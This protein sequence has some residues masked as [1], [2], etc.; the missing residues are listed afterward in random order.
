MDFKQAKI[1]FLNAWGALGIAWGVNKTTAQIFALLFISP[2]PL[3][4]EQ[5]MEE[6]DISRGNSSMNLRGLMDWDLIYKTT[7]KGDRREYF[8]TDKDFWTLSKKVTSERAKKELDPLIRVLKEVDSVP[9]SD[10]P[11]V[12]RFR[13]AVL[14]ISEVVNAVDAI[15]KLYLTSNEGLVKRGIGFLDDSK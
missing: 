12:R 4:V 10:D 6:L 15:L 5:I 14:N 11:Q 3:S 8:Y 9:V 2:E 7:K 13:D 1:E